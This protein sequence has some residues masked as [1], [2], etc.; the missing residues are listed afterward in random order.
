MG[1]RRFGSAMRAAAAAALALVAAR[2]GAASLSIE[3]GAIVLGRTELVSMVVRVDEPPG[4]EDRPLRMSVN[5]GSFSEPIRI[6]RGRY[7]TTY[8]PPPTRFPQVA[9]VAVWR[10]TGPEARI[11]FLRV[12]LFG[13]TRLPVT[14]VAGAAVSVA[15]GLDRF[16]PVTANARGAAVVPV[17]V[18][19]NAGDAAV[20]IRDRGGATATKKVPVEVPPYNR[21]TAALVP[22]AVV[23]D[24]KAHARID[25][26]YDLGGG[27]VTADRVRVVP[28]VGAVTF[29]RADS[30]RYV[31]RY[32]PPAG[33]TARQVE[34]RVVVEGDPLARA[35]ARLTLGLP[36]PTRVVLRPP[37]A[38]LVA[39]SATTV[40]VGALVLDAEGLGLPAQQVTLL[41]EGRPLAPV[42]YRGDGLYEAPLPAPATYP[43]GGLVRLEARVAGEGGEPVVGLA[44]L[45]LEASAAPRSVSARL[46]PSPVPADGRTEAALELEVR[47]AA[48]MPLDGAQLMVAA[49]DGSVT[50]LA[51]TSRGRYRASYLPPLGLPAAPPTLRVVDAAGRFER[52]V[53]IRLRLA[54]GRLLVGVRGGWA[55]GPGDLA[56]PRVGAEVAIPFRVRGAS[57][58]VGA[59]AG[60]ATVSQRL[61][62]AGSGLTA[63]SEATL[64][65]VA[66]RLAAEVWAGERL[67]LSAGAGALATFARFRTSLGAGETAAT[68][69][70]AVGFLGAGLAAGPGQLV[71]EL[72]YS[73]APVETDAARLPGGGAAVE[74]GYRLRIF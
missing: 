47:D 71:V 60:L 27:T 6:G 5:V 66:L 28:T 68:G 39:G 23:A 36:A 72:S 53:P 44:N 45:Q 30:G 64:V 21:L 10:E 14:A 58:S 50:G 4:S 17:V 59:T 9:L 54:P 73:Y 26:Q 19:P 13:Q 38:P 70:G 69:L 32:V 35:G 65:P 67:S 49:S 1:E 3:G 42:E 20:T 18:P 57:F 29:E 61:T 41:A 15:V 16:G 31:Y 55:A 24:G 34:F 11:D 22:H 7:R 62:D 12:P 46:S 48:G 51:P 33:T 43:P 25:V 2:A 52:S 56:G 8:V 63:R 40:T 37:A 74:A